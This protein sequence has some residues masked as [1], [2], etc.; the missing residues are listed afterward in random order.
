MAS[1][2]AAALNSALLSAALNSYALDYVAR[3]AVGGSNLNFFILKQLP[4]PTPDW[5]HQPCQWDQS[6]QLA[7][8]MVPRILE[9]TYTAVD[10]EQFALDLG[11]DGPP[12]VWDEERRFWLRAELDA[13]FFLIYGINREDVDYILETFPIVKRKDLA[14]HGSFRTKEAILEVYDAMAEAIRTGH[15]YETRLDPPPAGGWISPPLPPINARQPAPT[16]GSAA[17][18]KGAG[19]R[20]ALQEEATVYGGAPA[21]SLFQGAAP[22]LFESDEEEEETPDVTQEPQLPPEPI[23]RVTINGKSAQLLKRSTLPDSRVQYE[24]VLDGT[25]ELK[26]FISPPATIEVLEGG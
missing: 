24:V 16:D 11:F 5:F 1:I 2:E 17:K 7:T 3:S 19:A 21:P 13:A 9:L 14:A 12:F 4:T 18:R 26:S 6:V 10:M 20:K 22:T 25:G 8:W 15:C 23:G